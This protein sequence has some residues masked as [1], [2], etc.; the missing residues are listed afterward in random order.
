MNTKI[1][2]ATLAALLGLSGC[3]PVK[4]GAG[5]AAPTETTFALDGVKYISSSIG[6]GDDARTYGQMKYSISKEAR[7]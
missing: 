7:V 6:R 1:T 3:G 2:I 4:L 5:A